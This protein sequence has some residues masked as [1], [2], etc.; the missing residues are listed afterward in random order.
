VPASL[1]PESS[2]QVEVDGTWSSYEMLVVE[3]PETVTLVSD[4]AVAQ[5]RVLT[6]TF[7]DIAEVGNDG[8]AIHLSETISIGAI[9]NAF[10][11]TW[12]G[13][14]H[15]DVYICD[16]EETSNTNEYGFYFNKPYVMRQAE[17]FFEDGSSEYYTN[18]QYVGTE[19]AGTWTYA[20][21]AIKAEGYTMAVSPNGLTIETSRQ[22]VDGYDNGGSGPVLNEYGFY[23]E[24]FY[25]TKTYM[26]FYEN[27]D[28]LCYTE[29]EGG[30]A[31]A[32]PY[33]YTSNTISS[34]LETY[35]V[36]NNGTVLTDADYPDV[37]FILEQ[38]A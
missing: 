28:A 16:V 9:E 20:D 10:F 11:G 2:G 38:S 21:H 31:L 24:E 32:G 18:R 6:V 37:V 7:E 8:E 26:I 5:E 17:V 23:F 3:A 14:I 33:T 15:Y 19:P 35:I 4:G 36:S 30:S 29:G 22:Y 34:Q 13:K 1:T 27:G 25:E 12:S